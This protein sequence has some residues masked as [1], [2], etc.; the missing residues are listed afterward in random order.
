MPVGKMGISPWCAS[1]CYMDADMLSEVSPAA[2][3]E[4]DKASWSSSP[5]SQPS[6][7]SPGSKAPRRRCT[8]RALPQ[9]SFEEE[10]QARYKNF[11]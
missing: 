9:F 4:A 10:S 7:S 1:W 2:E 8:H 11:K 6:P 3:E 5:K